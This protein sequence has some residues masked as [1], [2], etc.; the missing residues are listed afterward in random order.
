MFQHDNVQLHVARIC[1]QLL[2]A[3]NVPVLPW[4][5]YSSDMLIGM[6]WIDVYASVLQFP[7]LSINFAKPL[8]RSG[9]TLH[10]PQSTA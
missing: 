5:A 4:L 2:E 10:N 3:E 6:R 9:T 1:T 7:P 8:K